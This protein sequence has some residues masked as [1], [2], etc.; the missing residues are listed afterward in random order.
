MLDHFN[1]LTKMEINKFGKFINSPYFNSYNT[2]LKLF[3]FL[4]LQYDEGKSNPSEQEIYSYVY[5][6]KKLN[7]LTLRKLISDFNKLF[8]KYLCINEFEKNEIESNLYLL[9]FVE[10]RNFKKLHNKKLKETAL[11]FEKTIDK[12]DTYYFNKYKFANILI[13][14]KDSTFDYNISTEVSNNLSHLD[15]FFI[16]TKINAFVD[17]LVLELCFENKFTEEKL[18]Y[19]EVITNI[20]NNFNDFYKNHPN[21]FINYLFL[22]LFETLDEKWYH[23]VINYFKLFR[24]NIKG[25]L[26]NRYYRNLLNYYLMMTQKNIRFE[27]YNKKKFDVY[28]FL[29][30]NFSNHKIIMKNGALNDTVYRDA[31]L[32]GLKFKSYKWV[33]IFMEKYKNYLVDGVRESVY[34]YCLSKYH[35]YQRDFNNSLSCLKYLTMKNSTYYFNIKLFL[36]EVYYEI[37]DYESI[38]Y[39]ILNFRKYLQRKKDKA[40]MI[41]KEIA[42]CNMKYIKLLVNLKTLENGELK[43]KAFIIKKEL[44]NERNISNRQWFIM[45]IDE[46]L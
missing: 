16:S 38:E 14:N 24:R 17:L 44:E 20:E 18:F 34:Y 37:G 1:N 4:K 10:N 46:L 43:S 9:K 8:E 36:F 22:K 23:Q 2:I 21:I 28:K 13:E 15:F 45:K 29:F 11:L 35:F 5:G 27:E 26:L 31:V 30:K 32:T 7:K 25:N 6:K 41:F 39:E 40:T 19:N 33:K 3:E 42:I 12:D